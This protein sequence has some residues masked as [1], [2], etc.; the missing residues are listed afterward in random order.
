M[1]LALPLSLIASGLAFA[2]RTAAAADPPW[3]QLSLSTCQVDAF[4]QANP[5]ID[6]QGIVIAVLD[7]GVDMGVPGL[8]KTPTGEMKV[9]DVQDFST[10]GDVEL[11]RAVWSEEGDHLIHYAA[12]GTPQRYVPP[13]AERRPSGSRVWFGLLKEEAFKNSSVS[14]VNDNGR[15]DDVFA[16]CMVSLDDGHDDD[17]VCFVDTDGD[18]DFSNER[19]LKSYR[20]NLDTFTFARQK[21]EKEATLLTCAVNLFPRQRKA[22]FHFDDGGHGTHVAGIAA[23]YRILNQDGFHGV[24]PGA[25][26]ISLKI[27]E[28]SLAGGASTTGAMKKAFEYAARFARE[29]NVTVVCNLSYGVGSEL[30][31][32]S[33]FDRYMEKLLRAN[34]GLI[35]CTSAGNEGPGLSSI[36]TP[37]AADSVIAVGALLAADTARDVLGLKLPHAVVTGFSSRGGELGKPDIA[38]PGMMSSTVPMWTRGRGDFW[39]GTSMASPYAA[40]MCALLA[41]QVREKVGAAPRAD[42][43]KRALQDSGEAIPGF[44]PLDYGAGRPDMVKAAA[45]VEE[46]ARS[47][48]ADP[49]YGF[50]V[51]TE[52]PL[53]PEGTGP[54][55]FWRSTH[56]PTDRPQAFTVKPVFVPQADA[57]RI[58]A[59]SKRLTLHCEAGWCE[60]LQDQIHFRAAQPATVRL[61]FLPDKLTEPGLHVAVVEGR[62]GDAVLLRLF[63]SVIVP[64][65]AAAEN[66]YR[67]LLDNQKVDGWKVQRHFFAVPA[68]ASAMH[69]TLR[70][71]GDQPGNAGIPQIYRPDGHEVGH[72]YAVRVDTRNDRRESSYT[73]SE[74]LVPGIWELPVVN[75][76]AD[77]SS[78]YSLEVRF[79]G[80]TLDPKE[81]TELSGKAGSKPSGSINILNVFDR[82]TTVNMSG[83]IEGY[84]KTI[85][86]TLKPDDDTATIPLDF[87]SAIGSV[88]IRLEVGDKTYAKFTDCAVSVFDASGKAVAK[89]GLNEPVLTLTVGNPSP[90]AESTS[91][92]LEIRPA[93]MHHDLDDSAEFD[94]TIDYLYAEPINIAVKRGDAS[95]VTLYPGIPLELSLAAEAVLPASPEGTRPIGYIRAT[96]RAAR[97]PIAESRI[98]L[99]K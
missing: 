98:H 35:V 7:T 82:P 77:E 30:E 91:G 85:R 18:R 37:A 90:D 78:A 32:Q 38:T 39:S 43:V 62:D 97:Q 45:R 58:T 86:K 16:V 1:R 6:G 5:K 57:D 84:R 22:V 36:G 99:T 66:G 83:Q 44:T 25:K 4:R 20:L 33:D 93:F 12:D 3:T 15:K 49:L 14:D 92:K 53:A 76:K 31:G 13:A 52:S 21:K 73:V 2:P 41:Q 27:G 89:D 61:R 50:E 29:H 19:P 40:G 10:Q 26:V 95:S 42:W 64:H 87:T 47:G 69:V 60:L 34:P 48:A 70:A 79:D 17:A 46:I 23:G 63:A 9:I 75:V 67:V 74:E 65:K 11:S 71:V 96:E 72:Y 51:S 94:I 28:N 80:V 56:F 88:R 59:F 54:A 8:Q 24:A 81:I 68:G 55:A